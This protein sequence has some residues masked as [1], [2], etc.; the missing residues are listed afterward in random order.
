LVRSNQGNGIKVGSLYLNLLPLP[1]PKGDMDGARKNG[2]SE[3]QTM[4]LLDSEVEGSEA[5][6]QTKILQLQEIR[7]PWDGIRRSRAF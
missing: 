6:V 4:A 3:E 1:P 7:Q 2:H 5:F